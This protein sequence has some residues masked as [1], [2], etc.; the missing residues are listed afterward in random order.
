MVYSMERQESTGEGVQAYYT[1]VPKQS[2]LYGFGWGIFCIRY[3]CCRSFGAYLFLA[4]STNH[5]EK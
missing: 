1:N 2:L 5:D 4:V 3:L